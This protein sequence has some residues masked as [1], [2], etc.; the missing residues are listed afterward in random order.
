MVAVVETALTAN[1]G[2]TEVI[3][4]EL[5]N[6]IARSAVI[7]A[8]LRMALQKVGFVRFNPFEETGGNQSFALALMDAEGNGFVISSLH[9]RTGTRVYG[10][11]LVAGRAETALSA[12]EI[13]AVESPSLPRAGAG[14]DSLGVTGGGG[15][16]VHVPLIAAPAHLLG[17]SQW[18]NDP[19]PR[20]GARGP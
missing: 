5:D 2:R 10:K 14:P 15:A 12:E 17:P 7:E 19:P 4:R 20:S 8:D 11:A 3:S 6:L 18:S 16:L 1:L 9:A 13:E